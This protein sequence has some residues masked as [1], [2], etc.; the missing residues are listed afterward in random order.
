MV[1]EYETAFFHANNHL[2][3]IFTKCGYILKK[4]RDQYFVYNNYHNYRTNND[5]ESSYI[6]YMKVSDSKVYYITEELYGDINNYI[7]VLDLN[8]LILV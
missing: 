1:F 6:G 8:K 5:T 2:N 3:K 4:T 7:S